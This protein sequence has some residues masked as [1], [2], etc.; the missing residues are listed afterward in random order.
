MIGRISSSIAAG[1]SPPGFSDKFPE[2]EKLRRASCSAH[3]PHLRRRET[4]GEIL[5]HHIL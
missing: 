1:I 4:R 2:W 3:T 5:F